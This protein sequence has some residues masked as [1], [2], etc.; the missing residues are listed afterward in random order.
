MALP[1]ADEWFTNLSQQVDR[2]PWGQNLGCLTTSS[3][4]YDT[5]RDRVLTG[6]EMMALQGLPCTEIAECLSDSFSDRDLNRF[7]AQGMALPSI[8]VVM[9]SFVL[10]SKAPWWRQADDQSGRPNSG[11]GKRFRT[12]RTQ[13]DPNELS[14]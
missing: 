14:V 13:L 3:L 10:N 2:K 4:V 11:N 12:A 6:L 8:A 7:A 5:K 9:F 1:G